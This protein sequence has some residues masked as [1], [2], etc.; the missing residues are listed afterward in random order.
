MRWGARKAFYFGK[1]KRRYLVEGFTLEDVKEGCIYRS[2]R[3]D[4]RN[5]NEKLEFASLIADAVKDE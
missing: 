1:G 4:H 2:Q 3:F 5:Q